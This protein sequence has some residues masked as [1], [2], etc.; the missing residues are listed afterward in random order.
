[1]E[2]SVE[3]TESG[4]AGLWE[5][6]IDIF[7]QPAAVFERRRDGK[8]GL[9]LLVLAVL[10]G[11][12]FFALHNG[13]APIMDAEMARQAQMIAAKNPQITT[14]QLAAQ[15]G[16]MEKFANVG[17]VLFVPIGIAITA[18]LMW[19]VAKFLDAKIAFAAAM[20]I[21]TYSTVPR[22]IETVI[23]AV[24]GLFL[25]P[26]SITSR[27]SVQVGPARFLDIAS[28]NPIVMTLLGGLDLFSIWTIV[29]LAIGVAVVAKVPISRGA[30]VGFMVWLFGL[31]P[32]L[33][34][35]M[36]QA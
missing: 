16:M 4:K 15:Q 32:S 17:F 14:E 20:M 10:S 6:F 28:A 27:Y 36:T 7:F 9:A 34:Q 21:A 26:E 30:I 19:V 23:N 13:I 3:T 8:F 29:L 31:L 1:M 11:V 33:Y 25:S 2:T 22:L 5:D 12:L 24:Q 35:A 18:A